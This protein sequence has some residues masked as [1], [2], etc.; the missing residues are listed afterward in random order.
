MA[1]RVVKKDGNIDTV[2]TMPHYLTAVASKLVTNPIGSIRL[3]VTVENDDVLA[4]QPTHPDKLPQP[5]TY[6]HNVH[7]LCCYNG[8]RRRQQAR[9]Y[10]PKWQLA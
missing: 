5:L 2:E 10:G 1:S 7:Q 4:Q 9:A 6:L 3:S 8:Q